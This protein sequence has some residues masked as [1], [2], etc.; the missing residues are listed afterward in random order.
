MSTLQA[1][2]R[3]RVNYIKD[4]ATRVSHDIANAVSLLDVAELARKEGDLGSAE[5]AHM[6]ARDLLCKCLGIS[7]VRTEDPDSVK[8]GDYDMENYEGPGGGR[9]FSFSD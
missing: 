5:S 7:P 3:H 2:L 9:Y 4:N 8:D 1:E 6:R